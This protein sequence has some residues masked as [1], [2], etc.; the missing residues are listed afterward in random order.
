MPSYTEGLGR[1][2]REEPLERWKSYWTFRVLHDSADFLPDAFVQARFDF[3][4]RRVGG[5]QQLQPRSRRATQ[6]IDL[7]LGEAVGKIYVQRYFSPEAKARMVR[8]VQ[9]LIDAFGEAIDGLEWMTDETKARAQEKRRKLATKIGYPDSWRDYSALSISAD[10]LVGN[11]RRAAA[12]DYDRNLRKLSGPVDRGEWDLTPQTVNAYYDP[13]KNE[14]VFPAAV[15][16]PP[17]FNLEADDAVNYGAIGAGIGHEIGHAFDDQGRRFDGDGN[18][19]DWWSADDARGFEQSAA[20]LVEGY[21]KYEPIDG[22]HVNGRL[23]LGENIGD[24]TGLVI[25]YAAYS[26]S[27]NGQE[28]PVIDGFT[29]PQRFFIGYA[30]VWRIKQRDEALR[31]YLLSDEHSPPRVRTNGP[32]GH[33]P[34]FYAAFDV[35]E[36]D[37]MWI[38]PSERVNIW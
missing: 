13:M 26:R 16:Q 23:T 36:G 32:L 21:G 24:L 7:A 8:L 17:F 19:R 29:G 10:D 35:R 27:T 1:L 30:Q 34:G 37:G 22:F 5:L 6:F 14:I 11:V 2:L 31:Q 9:N 3:E 15:L 25:A 33:I 38:P 4:G 12:F 18:L 28:P 20:R